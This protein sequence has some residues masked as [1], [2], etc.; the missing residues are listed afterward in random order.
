MIM[1]TLIPEHDFECIDE[2][3]PFD[4]LGAIL[5]TTTESPCSPLE[6]QTHEISKYFETVVYLLEQTMIPISILIY[7]RKYELIQK[8]QIA[9]RH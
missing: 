1:H 3:L 9:L 7:E 2:H 5:V 8:R 6:T 4:A